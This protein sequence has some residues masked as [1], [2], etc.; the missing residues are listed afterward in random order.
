MSISRLRRRMRINELL[1]RVRSRRL[2][3]STKATSKPL[4]GALIGLLMICVTMVSACGLN[5]KPPKASPTVMVD[6][7]LMVEPNLTKSLVSVL[8]E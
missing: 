6:A 8:S 2:A 1:C 7:S 5:S 3:Q 4:K